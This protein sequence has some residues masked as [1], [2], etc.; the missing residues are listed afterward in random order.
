MFCMNFKVTWYY[1]E[2]IGIETNYSYSKSQTNFFGGATFNYWG[3]TVEVKRENI[4]VFLGILQKL[5]L[6]V[7]SNF[8]GFASL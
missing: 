2:Q 1:G 5:S 6:F 3:R 7:M 4:G 8:T